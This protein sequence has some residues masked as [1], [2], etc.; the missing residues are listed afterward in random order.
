MV[1]TMA[2]AALLARVMRRTQCWSVTSS[3]PAASS[4]T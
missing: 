1:V 4:V 2:P 3:R